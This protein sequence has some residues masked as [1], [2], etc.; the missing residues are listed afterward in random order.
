L[1]FM[2]YSNDYEW[3][4][5]WMLDVCRPEAGLR[6]FNRCSVCWNLMV[7]ARHHG[8]MKGISWNH[9]GWGTD[10]EVEAL[11]DLEGL[12]LRAWCLLKFRIHD[13]CLTGEATVSC[14]LHHIYN[15]IIYSILYDIKIY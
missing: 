9:G 4:H 10:L 7:H 5:E 3:I 14:L 15:R 6:R 12:W 1:I 11:M 13:T 8:F 2:D